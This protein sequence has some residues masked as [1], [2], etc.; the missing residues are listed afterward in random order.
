MNRGSDTRLRRLEHNAPDTKW[1]RIAS[2][3]D[4]PKQGISQTDVYQMMAYAQLYRA[5]RLT[6]LYPHHPGL[7]KQEDVHARH[8]ITGHATVLETASIDLSRSDDMLARLR[9]LLLT[10]EAVAAA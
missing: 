5:P 9:R 3:I 2:R 8:W 10:E 6:L 4:D 7:G 1:K